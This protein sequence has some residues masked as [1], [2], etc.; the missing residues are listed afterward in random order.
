[1]GGLLHY[2]QILYQ[3]SC[4]G[5]PGT[6]LLHVLFLVF[7]LFFSEKVLWLKNLKTISLENFCVPFL[8]YYMTRKLKFALPEAHIHLLVE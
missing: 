4:Q 6:S 7:M 3:L 5:S 1:M 2:T 8:L